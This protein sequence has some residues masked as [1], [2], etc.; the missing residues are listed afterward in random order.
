MSL[1]ALNRGEKTVKKVK[2]TFRRSLA[3]LKMTASQ[4]KLTQAAPSK[5]LTQKLSDR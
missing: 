2:K 1:T 3:S 4:L 5:T